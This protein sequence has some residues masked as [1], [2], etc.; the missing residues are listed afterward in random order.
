MFTWDPSLETGIPL[1]DKHHKRMFAKVSLLL[2]PQCKRNV[3]DI[4]AFLEDYV[5]EHFKAEEWYHKRSQFPEA[6]EHRRMHDEFIVDFKRMRAEY[7]AGTQERRLLMELIGVIT[8]WLRN[9]IMEA[10]RRFSKHWLE[11]RTDDTRR[12]I[13][14][15]VEARYGQG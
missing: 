13:R 6:I 10:D 2:D 14:Q 1:I 3:G 4:L 7:Q 11:S 15:E 8:D 9:H 5:D 12:I